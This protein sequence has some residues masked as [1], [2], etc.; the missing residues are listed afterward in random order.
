MGA[1]DNKLFRD[2]QLHELSDLPFKIPDTIKKYDYL[3]YTKKDNNNEEGYVIS[4]TNNQRIKIKFP[5]YIK[6]YETKNSISNQES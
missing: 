4:D 2:I 5:T 1:Y 3:K 6:K